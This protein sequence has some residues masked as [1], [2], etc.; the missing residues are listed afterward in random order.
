VKKDQEFIS[1]VRKKIKK[2]SSRLDLPIK[3]TIIESDGLDLYSGLMII[4]E[5][6]NAI[7]SQSKKQEKVQRRCYGSLFLVT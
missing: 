2:I 1:N 4:N 3:S 7:I 6:L 5:R